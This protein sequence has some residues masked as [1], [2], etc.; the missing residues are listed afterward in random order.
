MASTVLRRALKYAPN[1]L[2]RLQLPMGKPV[3]VIPCKA[4][5]SDLHFDA[6]NFTSLSFLSAYKI[7]EY[8][9][10]PTADQSKR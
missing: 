10:E 7:L 5:F 6:K 4:F 9:F 8:K 1:V 3:Q 2:F